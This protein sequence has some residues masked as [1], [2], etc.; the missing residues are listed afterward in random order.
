MTAGLA[1]YIYIY[2]HNVYMPGNEKT[3]YNRI[4]FSELKLEKEPL[5]SDSGKFKRLKTDI[6]NVKQIHKTLRF[7]NTKQE[8]SDT[9]WT[10]SIDSEV[11]HSRFK[12]KNSEL[13]THRVKRVTRNSD[14]VNWRLC[15]QPKQIKKVEA[16]WNISQSILYW[17][18]MK[19]WWYTGIL[20]I[21]EK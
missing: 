19:R 7:R 12:Y 11:S 5:Q 13:T 6:F 2:T 17:T 15:P 4:R 1:S 8:P 10:N 9:T 14:T 18:R 3:Q 21:N 20:C 16:A